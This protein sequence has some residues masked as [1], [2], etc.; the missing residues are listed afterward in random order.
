MTNIIETSFKLGQRTV[1]ARAYF[2]GHM[3]SITVHID[4]E[5]II[6]SQGFTSDEY[7]PTYVKGAALA[8]YDKRWLRHSAIDLIV[9]LAIAKPDEVERV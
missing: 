8:A 4:N 7:T 5:P 6:E 2:N 3:L 1:D 9:D